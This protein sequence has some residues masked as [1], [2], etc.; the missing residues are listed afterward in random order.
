[1]TKVDFKNMFDNLS[2]VH[3][4]SKNINNKNW[5]LEWGWGGDI[6]LGGAGGLTSCS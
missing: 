3:I 4:I 5:G 1:M 6:W 2:K